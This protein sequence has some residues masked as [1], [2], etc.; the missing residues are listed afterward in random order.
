M[1]SLYMSCARPTA[2]AVG[3]ISDYRFIVAMS[4]LDSKSEFDSR[5]QQVGLVEEVVQAL[6]DK[7]IASLAQL[8]FAAGT[9][10]TTDETSLRAWASETLDNL[11][12]P[13]GQEIA[14][15]R[16]LFTAHTLIIASLK[17]EVARA[18]SAAD[19]VRKL[20][21]VE[22]EARL[23]KLREKLPGIDLTRHQ[24]PSYELV[25]AF[26][27]ML[28][29]RSVR[30]VPFHR[31]TSREQELSARSYNKELQ[32]MQSQDGKLSLKEGQAS[33]HANVS[34]GLRV[35]Q[36][37]SRRAAAAEIAGVATFDALQKWHTYLLNTLT[38]QPP[39]GFTPVALE[40]LTAA[41]KE[42]WMGVSHKVGASLPSEH[43]FPVDQAI[44]ELMLTPPV[45]MQL[46]PRPARA[47]PE[48][49]NRPGPPKGSPK[50][51][52]K[53]PASAQFPAAL[54]RKRVERPQLARRV[55]LL[56]LQ[57]G[58]TVPEEAV[59]I[60]ASVHEVLWVSPF[61]LVHSPVTRARAGQFR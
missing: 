8:G 24:E 13:L 56:E 35:Q 23:T 47:V 18:S 40:Q 55:A 54:A 19:V 3:S 10:G 61:Y 46:L 15:R 12:V 32:V 7:G 41:D 25:D 4:L 59:P 53:S 2:P 38:Q 29:A 50:G 1:F 42:L 6:R 27:A 37:M 9:P 28:E 39:Q 60:E 51:R 26:S 31:C 11:S 5:A 57:H 33:R 17:E 44:Q 30:W 43:D 58:A 48:R 34:D 22:R 21:P 52:G 49:V 16:L 14:L 45:A 36:A 20:P